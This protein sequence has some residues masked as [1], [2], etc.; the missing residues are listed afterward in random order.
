MTKRIFSAL[1]CIVL[2]LCIFPFSAF[3]DDTEHGGTG[4]DT[5]DSFYGSYFNA[6]KNSS[7]GS[8]FSFSSFE[9]FKLYYSAPIGYYGDKYFGWD[10]DH[11]TYALN[12]GYSVNDIGFFSYVY[13]DVE[14]SSYAYLGTI[15][16]LK[17]DVSSIFFDTESRYCTFVPSNGSSVTMSS[18]R[19]KIDLSTNKSVSG[20]RSVDFSS[21]SGFSLT[22]SFSENPVYFSSSSDVYDEDGTLIQEGS[23]VA[24]SVISVES[25]FELKEG[26]TMQENQSVTIPGKQG[27]S[28]WVNEFTDTQ[29]NIK[30][31]WNYDASD[32][33]NYYMLLL[34]FI[35]ESP[36]TASVSEIYDN[37][38]YI[39]LEIERDYYYLPKQ[40]YEYICKHANNGSFGTIDNVTNVL[41]VG[42]ISALGRYLN[43]LVP[44]SD[45]LTE[46]Y[47][48][49][50]KCTGPSPFIGL[51]PDKQYET[52]NFSWSNI[53][54]EAD[55][56]YYFY[57]YYLRQPMN[58]INGNKLECFSKPYIDDTY[59]VEKLLDGYDNS[60]DNF[61]L[62]YFQ[63]FSC[64]DPPEYS[65]LEGSVFTDEFF[66]S[67]TDEKFKDVLSIKP[68]GG[69]AIV[70]SPSGS[71]T[72][73]NYVDLSDD[74]YSSSTPW[75]GEEDEI[76]SD[77]D[78]KLDSLDDL[79][80]SCS[81]FF[82]LLKKGFLVLPT[83]FLA[84]FLTSFAV[85]IFLRIMGR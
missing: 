77:F 49:A 37:I 71:V 63:P 75:Y 29:Q 66:S 40:S 15:L 74:E 69:Q 61:E 31:T 5:F 43:Y 21:R 57:V 67:S 55:K 12:A 65:A 76:L 80:N 70:V 26:M 38:L 8:P 19:N 1:C 85:L 27:N 34:P 25:S 59:T 46:D 41:E 36:P 39:P 23:T 4:N 53:P 32:D 30:F 33:S 18:F 79:F 42:L 82:D 78:F 16:F 10:Q 64:S 72:E 2:I 68:S 60:T 83:S 48:G 54:I 9:S 51:Y 6:Y 14:S 62:V 22:I 47:V 52:I 56:T 3:A 35:S 7:W 13:E 44:K 24:T 28:D 81:N 50:I 73:G 84:L 58:D 45:I 11:L 17:S 20:D